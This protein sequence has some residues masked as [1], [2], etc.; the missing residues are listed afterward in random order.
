MRNVVLWVVFFLVATNAFGRSPNIVL[1]FTDDLG[2]Q[3]VGCFGAPNIETPNLDRMAEEGMRMT[4]FYS[5]APICSASRAGLLTGCYPPRVGV[6]GV[7]F[8]R[9]RVGLSPKEDT[10]ADVLKRAGYATACVGKWHLGHL[11]TYLPTSQGFDSYYGIPYSNDMDK[12]N[13]RANDLD[14]NWKKRTFRTWNVPLLK[15]EVIIERPTNQNTITKR[16]TQQA[17]N[18][19]EANKDS[20]FF[21]YLAH[22]MPHIP[23]FVS[24]DYY[25]DDP[26]SA[27]AATV[28]ELDWS[29]GQ[30]LDQL[31]KTGVDNDTLVVFT[32]D[33]GPWL[34]MKHHGGSALPLRDGKFTTYE[35]GMRVPFIARWPGSIPRGQSTDEIGAACDLLPTFAKLASAELKADR[36]IDGVDIWPLL[37]GKTSQSPREEFFYFR[38]GG[39]LQAVRDS[40][41]KLRLG[42]TKGKGNKQKIIPPELYN[43]ADDVSEANN[44]ADAHQDVVERLK[45]R[46]KLFA[47]EIRKNRRPEGRL[48]AA[49]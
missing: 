14:T 7:Y 8:P 48:A 12:L 21:L 9:H 3:D 22:S 5:M 43:L 49:E 39:R 28:E 15:N 36:K 47:D 27:Y 23:L 41:W 20:P 11:P 32:S 46:A 34:S 26:Q 24:D 40:K 4:S 6:T 1:I 35:G 17:I 33:N 31:K 29:V 25:V 44:V 30:I 19:I 38:G 37:S 42:S 18:F 13:G 2:Y 16:Y 45:N 10:I